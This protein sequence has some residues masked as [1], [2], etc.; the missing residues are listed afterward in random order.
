M[1]S[2][3]KHR[4]DQHD[5]MGAKGWAHEGVREVVRD[6]WPRGRVTSLHITLVSEEIGFL[7]DEVVEVL[8]GEVVEVV[9][10]VEGSMVVGQVVVDYIAGM[11]V[12]IVVDNMVEVFEVVV[13]GS[14]DFVELG[15]AVICWRY[16]GG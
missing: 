11:V 16:R 2:N 13:V 5:T 15:Y 10:V 14:L 8:V 7:E 9:E 12:G 3:G 4:Y 1:H 6:F